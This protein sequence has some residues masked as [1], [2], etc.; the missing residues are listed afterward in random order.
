MIRKKPG[1]SRFAKRILSFMGRY[2]SIHSASVE[3]EEEYEKILLHAGKCRAGF[4]YWW[5]VFFSI[6]SRIKLNAGLG[7][8]MFV[9]YLKV[10]FRNV[11]RHKAYSFINLAGLSVGI[12]CS[13]LILLFVRF[14]TSFDRYH[15]DPEQIYRIIFQSPQEFMGTNKMAWTPGALAP[16]LKNEFPEVRQT[17]RIEE[18]G[19][20]VSL[21]YKNTSFIENKFFYTDPGYLEIFSVSLLKG[22]PGTS[23]SH[24]F[25]LLMSERTARKYF[26]SRDP[27]GE[28]IRMNAK[29]DF[30]VT[31]IFKDIPN[32][33]HFHADFFAS[34][35][36][37]GSLH[38]E[39]D[40]SSWNGFN[41]QTYVRMVKGISP[42]E[43]E[44]K[45]TAFIREH[46][47]DFLRRNRYLLQPLTGIHLGGNIP[48][49]LEQNSHVKYIYIF[50]GVALLAILITCCNY[51]NLSTAR[52]TQRANEVGMRKVVGAKRI[53]LILPFLGE[54][55]LFTVSALFF[56]LGI[57]IVCLPS[58]NAFAGTTLSL[59][60]LKT[61]RMLAGISAVMC[62]VCLVSGYYPALYLSSLKPS[63]TLKSG[64]IKGSKGSRTFRHSLV[65]LQFII[66]TLLLVST[67]A[68]QKQ[69]TFIMNQY[70]GQMK[71]VIVNLPV[72]Q[73]NIEIQ[74]RIGIFKEELKRN[75]AILQISTSNW[76]PSN[77]RSGN[78]ALWEGKREDKEVLFHNL[79]ADYDFCDIYGI[80]LIKGRG[81][82]K[83]FTS[84]SEQ[85][86]LINE[87]GAMAMGMDNPLGKRFGYNR[88]KMGSIIGV[89]RDFPF[90]PLHQPIKPLAVRLR[91][92]RMRFIS[93]KVDPNR[94][95]R[96][97]RFIESQWKETSPGFA[98]SSSF[99]DEA[100]NDLYNSERR[101]NQ[102]LRFFTVVAIFLACLGLF[103]LALFSIEQR[104]KEVG[105]R[106]VLG[107]G[108]FDILALL[109]GD[110][111][112]WMAAAN[113]IAW[114][115]AYFAVSKWL[116]SFTYRTGI[117]LWIFAAATVSMI[118]IAGLAVTYQA[119]TAV[120]SNPVDSLRHE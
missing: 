82:T 95:S 120:K 77:I 42:A 28:T 6:I 58:F 63:Q 33:S 88:N 35:N 64:R 87:T 53:Q 94:L 40:L 13:L 16:A 118:G 15:Q 119:L 84:D 38:E 11:K 14:E 45:L 26:G 103:G 1:G 62:V 48:G 10:T 50:S 105:I 52:F 19:D 30:Q 23:L 56:A 49:E 75:P 101:L 80:N 110:F 54:S 112:K 92:D 7:G 70:T 98:F 93:I 71:E 97:M 34:F 111:L 21:S 66:S 61:P 47:A 96:T 76:L 102:I 2:E 5:Q 27:I 12:T 106:K 55:F 29:Y 107:A 83:D 89:I 9:H 18:S 8:S 41:Y 59:S 69:M 68:I 108:V 116:Q 73:D 86:Y 67:I 36:T 24:P 78:Y 90:V 22:D 60:L 104:T 100:V 39:E 85:A 37:L 113:I 79:Q 4:W 99:F 72:N 114:P 115:L 17:A 91:T 109:S 43:F 32:N 31:G 81:F 20:P 57:L 65:T 117:S 44:K 25:Y 51:I 46:T 3:L 74:E